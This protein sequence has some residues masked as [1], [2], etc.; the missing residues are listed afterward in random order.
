MVPFLEEQEYFEGSSQNNKLI[1][2]N[3]VSY[4]KDTKYLRAGEK[5]DEAI[6]EMK[7]LFN[8]L[9]SRYLRIQD[10]LRKVRNELSKFQ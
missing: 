8:D 9:M 1:S 7:Q 10:K 2:E 3:A 6:N 5:L 4:I